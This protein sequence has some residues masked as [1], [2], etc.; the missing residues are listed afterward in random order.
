MLQILQKGLYPKY[1]FLSTLFLKE[2]NLPSRQ[3]Q[4]L[5]RETPGVIKRGRV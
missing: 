4:S 5:L 1:F 3:H 2:C